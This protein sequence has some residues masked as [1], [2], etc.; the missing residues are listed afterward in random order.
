MGKS[1]IQVTSD[2]QLHFQCSVKQ[3]YKYSLTLHPTKELSVIPS[4]PDLI[5]SY[6][7]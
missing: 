1:Q 7:E 5:N 3:A 6:A 4:Q 2:P